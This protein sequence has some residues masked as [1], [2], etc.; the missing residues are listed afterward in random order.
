M[1]INIL[2]FLSQEIKIKYTKEEKMVHLAM[3]AQ[4]P[5]VWNWDDVLLPCLTN[6]RGFCP[7]A[8][9]PKRDNKDLM[10]PSPPVLGGNE[11]TLS[12]SHTHTHTLLTPHTHTL[13][14]KHSLCQTSRLDCGASRKIYVNPLNQ[15]PTQL[16][17]P[18]SLK[19][20]LF[21]HRAADH[22]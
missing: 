14:L 3:P 4:C 8:Y 18:K 6:N 9:C 5:F 11:R 10:S 2:A 13:P 16:R 19:E 22:N 21:P 15:W 17:V 1:V 7:S 12:L 20:F